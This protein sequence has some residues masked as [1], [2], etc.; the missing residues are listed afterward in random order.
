MYSGFGGGCKDE[1][2]WCSD[3]YDVH[4]DVPVSHTWPINVDV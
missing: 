1:K 4:A 2:L 3:Q